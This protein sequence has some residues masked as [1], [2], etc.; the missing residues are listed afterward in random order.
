MWFI[1][2]LPVVKFFANQN[3]QA[4]QGLTTD[5]DLDLLSVGPPND[6]A[7]IKEFI[8]MESDESNEKSFYIIAMSKNNADD[9]TDSLFK[10]A[11]VKHG[12][13]HVWVF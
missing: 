12:K 11:R 4:G 9:N 1:N 13:K 8:L 6:I 3:I 7:V 5:Y 2:G 10:F